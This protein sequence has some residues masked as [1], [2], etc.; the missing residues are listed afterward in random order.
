MSDSVVE[1]KLSA[2]GVDALQTTAGE[3]LKNAR[4]SAGIHIEALAVAL[5]VPVSKLEALESNNFD[6]LSDTVFLRALASS[7]CRALK[8]DPA[9]VLSLL[10]QS[11]AP[12]LI[13]ER[14]DINTPVKTA[15]K[16]FIT[17]K[18]SRHS[19]W[20]TASVLLLLAGAAAVFYWPAGYQPWD[21]WR[22]KQI[23]A[24]AVP[25]APEPVPPDTATEPASA[26]PTS[27]SAATAS[28]PVPVNVQMSASQLNSSVAQA[29]AP[30][31]LQPADPVI[32]PEPT[33]VP[34]M[35]RTR[36]E[37]WVQV[38]DAS[39]R[40]VFEKKMVQGEAAPVSGILPFSVVVGRADV[41]DVYVRGKLFELNS[42][43]RENVARF[44]VKQ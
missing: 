10:P 41:T 35:V 43:S 22:T 33:N 14:T 9:S 6:L 1:S 12:R 3:I 15:G 4:Q 2:D 16:T 17:T 27:P 25:A 36:G 30:V 42:V 8:L 19:S 40:V 44:E 13:P 11:Q 23:P 5:K 37:S 24:A 38:R 29:A 39:G 26:L 34:L 7:V 21:A 31:T 32:A 20:V 28:A 18:S